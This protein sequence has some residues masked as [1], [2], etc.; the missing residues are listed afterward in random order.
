M[1]IKV[2]IAYSFGEKMEAK[3]DKN[4]TELVLKH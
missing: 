4:K 1:I 2:Y 3:Q